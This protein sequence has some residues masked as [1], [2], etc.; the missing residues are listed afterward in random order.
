MRPTSAVLTVG[1][2]ITSG[3]RLDTNTREIATA[4]ASSGYETLETVSLPDDLELVAET[5]KRLCGLYDLV[6]CTGGLG[7]THDDVTRDAAALALGLAMAEDPAVVSTLAMWVGRHRDAA[8]AAQVM[9]QALVLQGAT[10]LPAVVGTAPGQDIPTPRGGRLVL[11][12]GPPAEMR[13]LLESVLA[14]DSDRAATREIACVGISE[15]D[16]QVRAERVLADHPGVRLA[17]LASPGDVHVVL[18]DDGAG[19]EGLMKAIAAVERAL[20]PFW[21]S[22]D[23]SSL[24]EMVLRRA[25]ERGLRLGT[26]ESCTGGLVSAALTSVPGSS[27][28]FLGGVVAYDNQVKMSLLGLPAGLLAQYGAVSEETARAMAE[29]ARTALGCDLAVSVTGIA[30]PDGGTADKPVGTIWFGICDAAGSRAEMRHLPGHRDGIRTRAT[31]TALDL[32]LKR[33]AE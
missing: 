13:P 6:V 21:Y 20:E 29:G 23:G 4:L 11:L 14:E 2:E 25:T 16:A 32:L 10:V 12:P 31:M 1:T 8:A 17:L 18:I 5:M 19:D 22:D 28:T 33:M 3:L 27:A 9:R 24:A 7:P 15:S 26:A 30:G